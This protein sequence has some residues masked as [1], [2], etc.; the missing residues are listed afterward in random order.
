M[1]KFC[2]QF[3]VEPEPNGIKFSGLFHPS[4]VANQRATDAVVVRSV[5]P[6]KLL[7]DP[8]NYYRQSK[9]GFGEHCHVDDT[10][11]MQ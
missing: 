6:E 4:Y 1:A 10:F 9:L 3:S 2:L 8:N 11:L 5:R 7:T